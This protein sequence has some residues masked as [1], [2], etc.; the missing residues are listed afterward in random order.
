MDRGAQQDKVA[1]RQVVRHE[2]VTGQLP[3]Q[4][5]GVV[6]KV[7]FDVDDHPGGRGAVHG[8]GEQVAVDRKG[9]LDSD[10]TSVTEVVQAEQLM[11]LCGTIGLRGPLRQFRKIVKALDGDHRHGPAL[12]DPYTRQEQDEFTGGPALL[13]PRD[14]E[15][16]HL[17]VST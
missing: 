2:V 16:L 6:R 5:G 13:G 4:L 1:L 12:A 7:L 15:C 9:I 14:D 17:G 10:L 11:R 8:V 3:D